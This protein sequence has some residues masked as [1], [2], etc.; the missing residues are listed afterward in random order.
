MEDYKE[1]QLKKG[2][3]KQGYCYR[4]YK[5]FTFLRGLCIDET[6]KFKVKVC[7]GLETTGSGCSLTS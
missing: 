1:V 3:R 6:S 5:R 7:Y 4:L 2:R